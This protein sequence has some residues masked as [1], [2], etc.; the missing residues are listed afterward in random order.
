MS[1]QL[2]ALRHVLPS[3]R[4]GGTSILAPTLIYVRQPPAATPTAPAC[5]LQ[6]TLNSQKL[7]DA[8]PLSQR[9]AQCLVFQQWSAFAS[10][11]HRPVGTD[12]LRCRYWRNLAVN[13]RLGVLGRQSLAF[14][15]SRI[16]EHQ[17]LPGSQ[18]A[19]FL[20][21]SRVRKAP[22]ARTGPAVSQSSR[23]SA[24]VRYGLASRLL[25]EL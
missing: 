2:S 10:V 1:P 16:Q 20:N 22:L 25:P 21:A 3:Y 12:Y 13:L 15:P 14:D 18:S 17:S 19:Q 23:A 24:R 11:L 6:Y 4:K 9:P 5:A 7:L 8:V